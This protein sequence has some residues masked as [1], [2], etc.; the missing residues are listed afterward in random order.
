MTSLRLDYDAE[1]DWLDIGF[2]RE[3]TYSRSY[4]LNDHITVY[5][6][7]GGGRITRITFAEYARLL[8]V[9]ETEFTSLRDEEAWVVDDL[10]FLLSRAPASSFLEVIDERALIARVKSPDIMEAIEA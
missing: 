5:T 2:G 8:M 4:A 3:E 7:P 10:L 1:D 9:N 6:D